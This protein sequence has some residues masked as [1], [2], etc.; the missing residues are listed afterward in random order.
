[1]IFLYIIT[2]IRY[3]KRRDESLILLGKALNYVIILKLSKYDIYI[4][5]YIKLNFKL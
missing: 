1:M 3:Q 4:K 2:I 5:Y